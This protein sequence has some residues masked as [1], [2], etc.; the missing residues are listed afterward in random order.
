MRFAQAGGKF[1]IK[2]S[3]N[4]Y[5]KFTASHIFTGTNLLPPQNVLITD[6]GGTVIDILPAADAGDDV[7]H[8]TGILCPGFVNAHCHLELSHLRNKIPQ[9]TG[10][11]DFVF[12]IITQ[13]NFSEAEILAAITT[14]EAEMLQNGI[15]AVGDICNTTHTLSQKGQQKLR[16]HNFIEVAGFVP[17]AAQKRFDDAVEIYHQFKQLS[18][19]TNH[20]VSITPHA[21]YS[22]SA[23]LFALINNFSGNSL[24]TI[25]NQET[26]AENEFF[27]S[28]TGDFISLYKNLG[29]DISFYKPS[30]KSS[31]QTILPY[32]TKQQSLIL[33]H[34]VA[35]VQEDIDMVTL[36][37]KKSGRAT[38]N[39]QLL[40]S[41]YCLCP[42][43]N[44]YISNTLPNIDI[45]INNGCNIVLGTDSL[46][47]NT[48][49]CIVEEM[50]TLQS[51]FSHLSLPQILQWAT[52]NGAAALQMNDTLGS[53]KAGKKPG[54]V[55][56]EGVSNL[57]LQANA[58][59]RRIL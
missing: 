29:V 3:I 42:N 16:Y 53:F 41:F 24:L 12:K 45:L 32:F 19:A 30:G 52:F 54:V 50:I 18:T 7:E 6:T 23:Q 38:I 46:A 25:H 4:L 11:V 37:P 17:A 56:I 51:N 34:D 47:S 55:L 36:F 35:T 8:F 2:P 1:T 26:P 5:R 49:L 43:A 28:G 14:A 33:V 31:L 22:V 15:V 58:A 27:I 13:R 21:P 39:Q 57:Q 20:K 44:Q 40:S 59:A 9:H 48:Q 10:L